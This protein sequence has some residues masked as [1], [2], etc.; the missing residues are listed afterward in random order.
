MREDEKNP[1]GNERIYVCSKTRTG[2]YM[3]KKEGKRK[4]MWLLVFFLFMKIGL[5]TFGGG[6]AMIGLIRRELIDRRKWITPEEFTDMIAVSESTPGPL[7]INSA[8]YVGYKVGG[9][10][11]ALFATIG[12]VIPSFVI[13]FVISLFLERFLQ[14]RVVAAAFQGIQVAVA[15]LILSAGIKLFRELRKNRLTVALAILVFCAMIVLDAL[16]LS[17][18]SIWFILIGAGIGLAFYIGARIKRCRERTARA[19][20]EQ[21]LPSVQENMPQTEDPS[22]RAEEDSSKRAEEDKDEE[23]R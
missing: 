18:S 20:D 16:S 19:S 6:Y 23:V 2:G 17:F 8:T 14:I 10:L 1:F 21:S 13:I 4:K 5:F 3:A 9:F 15:F 7:A 12:V 11:G 22:K